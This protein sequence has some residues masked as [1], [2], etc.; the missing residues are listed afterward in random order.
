MT[1]KL[2]YSLCLRIFTLFLEIIFVLFQNLLSS[3]LL[4]ARKIGGGAKRSMLKTPF[5]SIELS[6]IF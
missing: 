2:V 3:S 6:F 5:C 4:I 1:V